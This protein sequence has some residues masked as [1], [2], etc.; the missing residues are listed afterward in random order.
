MRPALI[1]S[2]A[3]VTRPMLFTTSMSGLW[4]LGAAQEGQPSNASK[5]R[6]AQE[7][8]QGQQGKARPAR[9]GHLPPVPP[10]TQKKPSGVA[11]PARICH[12]PRRAR[13]L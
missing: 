12:F 3:W 1:S 4:I 2:R 9:Q 5:A 13:S 10:A 8:R 6:P 11:P 7:G